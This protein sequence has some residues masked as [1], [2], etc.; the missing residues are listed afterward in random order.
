MGVPTAARAPAIRRGITRFFS[1]AG[2]AVLSEVPLAN[3]RRAD[4]IALDPKGQ[5]TLVEIKSGLADLRAD[6]KWQ[7]YLAFADRFFFA[8]DADFPLDQLPGEVGIL[9]AD[10]FE[11]TVIRNAPTTTLAT[12]RRKAMTLRFARLA[13]QRLTCLTDP[14]AG[15]G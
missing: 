14:S 2:A 4:V 13:A 3:G 5:L 8:V 6:H 9:V 10:R 1:Q 12:A 15:L 7:D 11:A